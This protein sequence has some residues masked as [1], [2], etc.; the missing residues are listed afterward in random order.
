MN[1]PN[2]RWCGAPTEAEFV[3]IG[4]GYQQVTGGICWGCNCIERGPYMN[5]GLISEVEQATMWS[6]PAEDC[7]DFSPFNPD[8][9][10]C[11][12]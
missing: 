8:Q 9:Q 3:D 4:V 2:C 10:E 7:S 1:G 12:W 6:G 11:P 5:D